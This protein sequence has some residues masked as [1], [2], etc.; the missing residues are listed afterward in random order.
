M[1]YF[2][3]QKLNAREIDESI[4]RI[5]L[6]LNKIYSIKKTITD[7]NIRLHQSTIDEEEASA[8]IRSIV[9][10]N[11][12]M[13]IN[14]ENYE[15]K[16]A[17]YCNIKNCVSSNS[18]SSAN[19]LAI[20]A[21]ISQG[22]LKKGDKVLVPALAWSTTIFPLVQ[23]G[24]IPVFIDQECYSYN[25]CLD[26][27]KS[28]LEKKDIAAIMLIHTYGI[29]VNMEEIM[30]LKDKFK[31]IVIEDTCESMGSEW[32]GKKTGTWGD[33]GT[34]SSYYSHHICTLEGGLTITD[35]DSLDEKMR[36]IRSHG[37]IRNSKNK[38]GISELYKNL[39]PNFLFTEI[40][41]NLRLSD[42]QAS[43]GIQ[44]IEKLDTFIRKR[45]EA[46]SAYI[47]NINDSELKNSINYPKFS[48]KAKPSWFGFP[49][50]LKNRLLGRKDEL[51]TFLK[52]RNI[53]SRPFLC[54]DFTQQPVM[55][56]ILHEKD[57]DL[58]IAKNINENALALPCHQGITSNDVEYIINEL[59]RFL[60][61][62]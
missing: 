20:A 14:N 4:E 11:I 23:F 5:M 13:G 1:E 41:Y 49:I 53:E 35:D 22:K 48:T 7:K 21:L 58:K 54:G 31:L 39:D 27:V 57:D 10:G 26:K 36:S 19:L 32:R 37:W 24:L 60:Q 9:D 33:V 42:P 30:D 59:C 18:G 62:E 52:C 45:N 25:I 44:Q 56:N 3:R 40:G 8:L 50:I 51:R 12:T 6:E 46:A 34:F 38:K 2:E 28:R 55:K 15:S 29:P 61:E 47:K 43:I 16:Y 17:K